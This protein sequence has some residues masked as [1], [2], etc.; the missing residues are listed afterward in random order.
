MVEKK[1]IVTVFHDI[2]YIVVKANSEKE[3]IAKVDLMKFFNHGYSG[4][5]Q[6]RTREIKNI[7]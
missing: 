2:G 1:F 3:A 6:L 4:N 5:L 7:R